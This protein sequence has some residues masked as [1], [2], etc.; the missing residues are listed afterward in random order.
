M[1]M[2][3]P[4]AWDSIC[5]KKIVYMEEVCPLFGELSN[6][7]RD[8]LKEEGKNKSGSVIKDPTSFFLIWFTMWLGAHIPRY[9]L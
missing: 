9:V 5:S 2:I 1:D 8:H 6:S 4:L 7:M 3:I